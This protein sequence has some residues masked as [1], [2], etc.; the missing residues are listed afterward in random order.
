MK[1]S[2]VL[3][4]Y[5]EKDNIIPLIKDIIKNIK[6]I[7]KNYEIVVVDDN[8]PDKTA[9][10]CRKEFAKDKN[11][12]IYVRK[13]N[14]GFASAILYGLRKAKGETVFVM[15]TDFSH[16]P[17]LIPQMATKSSK[18]NVVIGSR[19][20]KNGG[21]ENKN[22][23]FLSKIYNLYL[24]YLLGIDISDFL[25]GYFCAEKKFLVKN[26][27]LDEKIFYGFGDYFIRFAYYINKAGGRFFEIPAFYKNRISGESKSNLINMLYTYTKTSIKLYFT[28]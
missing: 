1:I 26:E 15:D 18:Y 27:L 14:K 20:A 25:F 16:N 2:V 13:K 17:K 11:V 8:S 5:N 10:V 24:K 21:G 9:E 3:P 28:D 6:K 7:T 12:I 19:Y 4:T 22:R 23:Y